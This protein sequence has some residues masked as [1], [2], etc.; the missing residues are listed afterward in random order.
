MFQT[1]LKDSIEF[2]GIG[3]HS[4]KFIKIKLHPA[5]P[6]S[7]VQF[8]RSDIEGS[9]YTKAS[10]YTVTSTQLATTINCG[11]G[12]ISTIEHLMSALYGLGVDNVM[13]DVS[14]PEM[15]ILDGSAVPYISIINE[16]GIK[17][18][19]KKRKYLKFKRRIRLERDNKWI[20]I[21]PSRYTKVTFDIDFDDEFIKYQKAFFKINPKVYE[22][23]IASARTFGFKKDVDALWDMGLARGGSLDNAVVIDGDKV[24]NPGG[25]RFSDECVRHKVLDLIGDISLIGYR[26]F[27]HIRASKSGH[28]LNNIFARTL[29][30]SHN[31]YSIVELDEEPE[32]EFSVATSSAELNPQGI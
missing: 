23:E 14:G 30:E 10:P 3:L 21:I 2:E 26:F 31:C 20:E 4:G 9:T 8:L 5:F 7:G 29:L 1:T 6:D 25:L 12:Q 19:N 22:E 18:L 15:P 16:A 27:G 13:V 28:L 32:Y 24:L 17:K 11:K